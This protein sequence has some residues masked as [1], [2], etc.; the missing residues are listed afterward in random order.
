MKFGNS[1]NPQKLPSLE[2]I[3]WGLKEAN[4]RPL[5]F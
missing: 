4:N 5:N 3:D 1:V 2:T